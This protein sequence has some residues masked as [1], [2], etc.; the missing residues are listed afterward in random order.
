[1]PP[2]NAMRQKRRILTLRGSANE[3]I[4]HFCAQAKSSADLPGAN[5]VEPLPSNAAEM[6]TPLWR[7][8]SRR[9]N[10]S[11]RSITRSQMDPLCRK[12]TGQVTR[13][14]A[15]STCAAYWRVLISET[16]ESFRVKNA[17][18][19]VHITEK[20]SGEYACLTASSNMLLFLREELTNLPKMVR[21]AFGLPSRPPAKGCPARLR[22]CVG[23]VKPCTRDVFV[24]MIMNAPFL[25]GA[26]LLI[27][28]LDR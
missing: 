12:V 14:C 9:M 28:H 2:P 16:L 10:T 11:A 25:A 18:V 6:E 13:R 4:C 8:A 17:V 1:M 3:F 27:V 19:I 7:V 21:T 5:R 26:T 24:G 20:L 23:V 15:N 22:A